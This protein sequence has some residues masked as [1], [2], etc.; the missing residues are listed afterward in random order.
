MEIGSIEYRQERQR[1]DGLGSLSS[2][3]RFTSTIQLR[4]NY[5]HSVK[6]TRAQLTKS[7]PNIYASPS[8]T[9][10]VIGITNDGGSNW[11]PVVMP[12]GIYT[13]TAITQALRDVA[14]DNNY[15]SNP[16]DPGII[17]E[18]NSVTRQIFTILDNSKTTTPAADQLGIRFD[19]SSIWDT[20]GY[21][22]TQQFVNLIVG[23]SEVQP[24]SQYP[25]LDT[26]GTVADVITNLIPSSKRVNSTNT[27][28][29]FSIPLTD[30]TN[31]IEYLYPLNFNDTKIPISNSRDLNAIE[32]K[33]VTKDGKDMV[34]TDGVLYIELQ[35]YSQPLNQKQHLVH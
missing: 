22:T 8:F 14:N 30:N 35:L 34:V 3:K 19:L 15:Y 16:A 21:A 29:L 26:Q 5:A 1:A 2:T 25:T 31:A 7:I 23:S 33:L 12:N 28:V 27:D 6:V 4:A 17:V 32:V 13:A 10:N 18:V 9:N 11:I 24:A 20:L